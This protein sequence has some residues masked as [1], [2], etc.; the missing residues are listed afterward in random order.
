MRKA[1]TLVE[2]LI[3]VA[4]VMVLIALLFPVFFAAKRKSGEPVCF[5][6]PVTIDRDFMDE[7]T[8][9][10]PE[11]GLMV[12]LVHGQQLKQGVLPLKP[13]NGY[14]GLVLAVGRDGAMQRK[15][16]AVRCYVYGRG[17]RSSGR[18]FFTD[19]PSTPR[20]V[21][22]LTAGAHLTPCQ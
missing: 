14:T 4:I 13:L 17:D 19:V 7:L 16:V 5:F 8:Q 1:F 11:F 21:S 15:L 6:P 2:L 20:A 10:D 18:D 22:I 12:C 3:V 9:Q